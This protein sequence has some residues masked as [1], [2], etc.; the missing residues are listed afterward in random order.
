MEGKMKVAVM[1]G[2]GKMGYLERDIPVPKD[3]EVLVK[4]QYVGICGSDLHYYEVGRMGDC[5]VKPPFVL[6]HERR[7]LWWRPEKMSPT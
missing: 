6:G 2:I 1:E 7:V 4:L 5:I 3:D